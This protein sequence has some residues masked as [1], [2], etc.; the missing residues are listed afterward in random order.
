M[1]SLLTSGSFD[2]LKR[3]S[4]PVVKSISDSHVCSACTLQ[5][6]RAYYSVGQSTRAS[7]AR[8]P[9]SQTTDR[10]SLSN[11]QTRVSHRA[12]WDQ[13][14]GR[15]L[16]VDGDNRGRIRHRCQ[17]ECTARSESRL[18]SNLS[19]YL[20]AANP[21]TESGGAKGKWRRE[22]EKL[23]EDSECLQIQCK[24]YR[25]VIEQLER[26]YEASKELDIFRRYSRLKTMIRRTIMH[27][28]MENP[29]K[30][31]E[32]VSKVGIAG[33]VA[34]TARPSM[35]GRPRVDKKRIEE[36][37]ACEYTYCC[38]SQ[39]TACCLTIA[40]FIRQSIHSFYDSRAQRNHK[41]TNA[42]MPFLQS[43]GKFHLF[44][45]CLCFGDFVA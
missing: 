29:Q 10:F 42:Q 30:G 1:D 32:D 14:D 39:C 13:R 33:L 15:Q 28:R 34:A 20:F 25:D 17:C 31:Q 12:E 11:T 44:S 41:S 27:V 35:V 18:F 24:N 26:D 22:N 23:C 43:F 5:Q 8:L 21:L 38:A 4:K 16:T 36:R 2:S 6:Y 9:H 3:Q 45:Y 19:T 37:Y 40:C 7:V